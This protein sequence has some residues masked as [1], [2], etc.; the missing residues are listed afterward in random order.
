MPA[1]LREQAVRG[2]TDASTFLERP[3]RLT[4]LELA[5]FG[6]GGAGEA[7]VR[8]IFH[9]ARLTPEIL[10]A[11]CKLLGR[12]R[13]AR[14]RSAVERYAYWH[15]ARDRLDADTWRRL[16][17]GTAILMYHAFGAD[18]EPASRYV[19]P[20]RRFACQ[21]RGIVRSRRPVLPLEELAE[22]WRQGKLPPAGA[23]A[24]TSDDGYVDNAE[25]AAPLLRRFGL[26]ATIFVVAGRA[27]A[28][29]DWDGAG[30]LAGRPLLSW[31]A[32]RRLAEGG[33]TIGAH[34]LTHPRLPELG[35]TELSREVDQSRAEVAEHV[36]QMPPCFAYPYGRTDEAALAAVERAGFLCACGI[37]RGLNYPGTRRF[38]LRRVPVHGD[39][40][41][42][43]F[44]VGLRFGDPDLI[45][46]AGAVVRSLVRRRR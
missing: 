4:E 2:R 32:L 3:E 24:I 15:G 17:R 43:S 41:M 33:V 30:P 18:D 21:I 44:A 29:A 10:N 9:A 5:D 13:A 42:L 38:D 35:A 22:L 31:P 16:T 28:T 8:R 12:R 1:V 20:V 19:L 45:D 39:S 26:P 27:G 25:L 6:A 11:A 36:G 7:A 37:E 40:S 34:T 46:R 23:V 14:A